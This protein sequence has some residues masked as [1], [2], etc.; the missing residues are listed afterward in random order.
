[1]TSPIYLA[2]DTPDA[3][4]ARQLVQATR[5]CIAGV[6]IGITLWFS[7]DRATITSIVDDLN[8]FLD[9]KWHDI[10]QQVA[11]AIEAV[12]PMRPT[13]IS[14][15][16]QGGKGM[17][18]AAVA[19]ACA[20]ART[21]G[22]PRPQLLAVTTLT[23]Q[24]ATPTQVCAQAQHAMNCGLDG[25]IS[26]PQELRFLRSEIGTK[27]ILMIPGIRGPSDPPDDHAR[28]TTPREAMDA[29]ANYIVIGRPIT[30]ASDPGQ[31]AHDILASLG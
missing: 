25:V 21:Q 23:S 5:D 17:L 22:L 26:S 15:H 14:L 6:K 20:R 30:Q 18:T 10:P 7:N 24:R 31:A 27:P 16:E 11:G 29:G 2:I 4:E 19:A 9:V 1:M 28:T 12:M 3:N 13:F 8:W